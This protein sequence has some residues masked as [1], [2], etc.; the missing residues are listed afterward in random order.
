MKKLLQSILYTIVGL[1]IAIKSER[2]M[3]FHLA[4]TVFILIAGWFFYISIIEWMMV[5][6]CIG[7]VIS[8]ELLNTA[9][10]KLVDVVSK[11]R[12]PELGKIKD[13]A[14]AAVLVGAVVAAIVGILI[15]LPKLFFL[16]NTLCRCI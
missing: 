11:E 8:L 10:E 7:M 4:F 9:I 13:I 12:R 2:S 15:F 14:G 16:I 5:C 6:I 3:K 1:R